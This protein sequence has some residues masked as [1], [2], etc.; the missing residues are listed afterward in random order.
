MYSRS[1][2]PKAFLCRRFT[3]TVEKALLERFNL[4]INEGDQILSPDELT[5]LAIGSQVLIVTTTESVNAEVLQ[6]LSSTLRCIA[7]LSVGCDH[8]DT[9]KAK[10]L[11]ISVLHIPDIL[12]DTYAEI[13]MMLL[14]NAC[15][16]A[17]EADRLVRS[18]K[19]LGWGPTQLLGTRLKGK[20]MLVFGMGHIGR[21]IA[22][23]ARAFGMTIHYH[24]RQRL[25]RELEGDAVFHRALDDGLKIA[26]VLMIAA[27]VS[28]KPKKIIN[29]ERIACMPVGAI[30]VNI[31]QGELIEDAALISALSSGRLFAAGLDVFANEPH[32]DERYRTLDNVFLTPNIGTAAYETHEAMG[33]MLLD[34][35]DTMIADL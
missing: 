32:I 24:N 14:L 13:A 8:I 5:Q 31:S 25:S 11:G 23:R 4:K 21:E 10:K 2:K 35:L 33:K 9:V 29:A 17:Y 15:R 18:G 3:P 12:C 28:A 19:W 27:P 20:R 26:D 6:R 1:V 16:R 34:G 30:V 7:T 22:H